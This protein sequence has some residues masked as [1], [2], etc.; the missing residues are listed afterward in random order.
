MKRILALAF[1]SVL[2]LAPACNRGGGSAARIVLAAAL[3]KVL[4]ALPVG[5][6][7][8]QQ[9]LARGGIRDFTTGQPTQWSSSTLGVAD[10]RPNA[11]TDIQ[12]IGSART[13]LSAQ[14]VTD[15]ET[16]FPLGNGA[17]AYRLDTQRPQNSTGLPAGFYNFFFMD[18]LAEVPLSDTTRHFQYAFVGDRDGVSGNN[19]QGRRPS[20]ATSSMAPTLGS[21]C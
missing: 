16:A 11:R 4:S 19:Y 10:K 14:D 20:I 7:L 9:F 15:F 17:L 8:E 12:R 2:V 5:A 1:L 3:T 21:S 6:L 13:Y 18:L